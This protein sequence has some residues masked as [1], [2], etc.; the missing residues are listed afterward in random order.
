M[1]NGDTP[2]TLRRSSRVPTAVQI[3]VTSLDGTHFSE[4]CE[5]LVVNAHGCAMH[6]PVK[7]DPGVPLH[8]HSKDGRETTAYVVSCQ[9]LG[10]DHRTWT[11]GARLRRPENFWGLKACPKDWT[12]WTLPSS[13][14]VPRLPQILKTTN[15]PAATQLPRVVDSS[16]PALDRAAQ[17]EALVR[18]MIAESVRPLQADIT[19]VKEI[20][21]R[22]EAN[23]SRFEVSL[24]SIPPDLEQKLESR[25]RQNLGPRVLDE[26][27]QQSA[28]LLATAKATVERQTTEACELFMRRAAE[29]VTV[30]EKKAQEISTQISEDAGDHLR[31]GLQEFHQK[32][33][34]GGNS[35]KH[36]SE[37]LLE[38]LRHSLDAEFD[39]RRADKEN[40]RAALASESA[41]LHEEVEYLDTRIAKLDESV[42]CLEAGLDQRLSRMSSE[43]VRDTR[44]QFEAAAHEIFD[45]LNTRSVRALSDQLQDATANL[46][47]VQ[48]GIVASVSES[49]KIQA[50]HALEAF[51]H[52]MEEL[53]RL[54][55]ERCRHRLEEGLNALARSVHEQFSPAAESEQR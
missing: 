44:G 11:L 6:T 25:L 7:L 10:P 55:V 13:A 15:V 54:S 3:L 14:A 46:A 30:V 23:P 38:F 8:F 35:L 22:R 32:L 21:A 20:L 16:A 26:T 33:L 34:Q 1:Q 48:N 49:L 40:V 39:A 9:P 53:T 45:E 52:S 47:V 43:T 27:R 24:S 19:A 31:R 37:D 4:V 17:A 29:Q 36:L 42:H 18:K 28:H 2:T 51:E 50:S 41:R 5:T 12:L